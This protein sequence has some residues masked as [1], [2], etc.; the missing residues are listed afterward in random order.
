M[1]QVVVKGE[2]VYECNV[3]KRRIRVPTNRF[4]MDVMQRC[5]ITAGCKGKLS[6]VT[7]PK[8]INSTP[9]FPAEVDG[10]SD[11]FQRKILFTHDQPIASS[12]WI[13]KHDLGNKPIVHVFVYTQVNGEDVLVSQEP[14]SVRTVDLNT[15]EVFFAKPTSGLVQCVSLASEN[16]TNSTALTPASNSGSAVQITND[17]SD[18]VIAT[19]SSAPIVDV[20]L[21]FT[22]TSANS[23]TVDILYSGIDSTAAL[24][25]PWS[26]V[27]RV[28]VNGRRYTVR[29]FNITLTEAA[30][31]AFASGQISGGSPFRMTLIG[32][33]VVKQH[34]VL[35]LLARTPFSV[36][37]RIYDQYIDPALVDTVDPELYW[38]ASKG[39]SKPNVLRT[40]YPPILVV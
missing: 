29:T 4:G 38:D 35:I 23:P 39:Y 27:R 26:G 24:D 32:D 2:S 20:T 21:S 33:S 19:L 31:V 40:T 13:V 12:I 16:L 11:W 17:N 8:D 14:Q 5:S 10:V 22:T 28:M 6:R 7:Q 30:Q 34:D 1:K 36:V 37:D 18:L 15:I 3:C 9:A 25:S